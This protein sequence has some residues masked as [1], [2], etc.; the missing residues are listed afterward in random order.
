MVKDVPS[1]LITIESR[2]VTN[3]KRIPGTEVDTVF[4]F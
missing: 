4:W 2:N 1:L 3:E